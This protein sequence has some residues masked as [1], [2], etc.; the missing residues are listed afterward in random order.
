[1]KISALKIYWPFS[2]RAGVDADA[3]ERRASLPDSV[4]SNGVSKPCPEERPETTPV[5]AVLEAHPKPC[6][7]TGG[8]NHGREPCSNACISTPVS[9]DVRTSSQRAKIGKGPRRKKYK[10]ERLYGVEKPTAAEVHAARLL[11]D[12]AD[13]CPN[14]VG[15]WIT[16]DELS[17]WYA[18]LAVREGWDVQGWI[19]VAIALKTWTACARPK[20][21]TSYLIPRPSPALRRRAALVP[22]RSEQAAYA[23]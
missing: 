13:G 20:K 7:S 12:I 22:S 6:P 11:L 4:A 16:K 15:T 19:P 9:N 8:A 3:E 23:A 17:R 1:M 5:H 14:F 21:R 2:A 18:E 10:V